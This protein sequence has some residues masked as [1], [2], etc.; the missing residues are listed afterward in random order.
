MRVLNFN[1]A[2]T[3]LTIRQTINDEENQKLSNTA[4]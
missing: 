4:G 1:G 3:E 2:E